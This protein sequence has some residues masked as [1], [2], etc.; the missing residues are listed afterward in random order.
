M[1][2]NVNFQY[3][4]DRGAMKNPEP[5]VIFPLPQPE[6]EL[7]KICEMTSELADLNPDILDMIRSD[8]EI[9]G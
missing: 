5:I 3:I 2:Q 1:L 4:N 6:T 7:S 9:H 8:Q